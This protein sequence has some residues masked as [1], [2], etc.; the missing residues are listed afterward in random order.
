MERTTMVQVFHSHE[1]WDPL[2]RFN[3][4]DYLMYKLF[5]NLWH[6]LF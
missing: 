3:I 1:P 2:P 4:L 5:G 6:E